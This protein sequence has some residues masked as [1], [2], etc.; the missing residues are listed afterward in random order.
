MEQDYYRDLGRKLKA[1]RKAKGMTLSELSSQIHR[2]IATLSKYEN[3][4]VAFSIDAL[5]D[6]CT[7]LNIDIA[8]LLPETCR[9]LNDVSVLKYEKF[10]ID[11]L[12]VY[13][14]NGELKKIRRAVIR[15]S[16]LSRKSSIYLLSDDAADTHHVDFTY[17]GEVA[18]S[19]TSITFYYTNQEPPFDKIFIR[20]PL[21]FPKDHYQTGIMSAI[22]YYYQ[23]VTTKIMASK[24]PI[25]MNDELKE[26]LMINAEEIKEIRRSNMLIIK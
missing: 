8:E 15:N 6:I 1:C 16:N 22:T 26:D 19:D 11:R 23:G 25:P 12:Y 17:H 3:G 10:F 13:W 18:Y 4:D 9:N 24:K 20:M 2:S 21:L 5:V 7:V 14:Y